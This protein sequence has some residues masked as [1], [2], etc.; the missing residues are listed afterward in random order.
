MTL[1]LEE[2]TAADEQDAQLLFREA[3]RRRR[4]LRIVRIGLVTAVVV[5]LVGFGLSFHRSSSSVTGPAGVTSQPGWP[6]HLRTGATLVYALNDLRVLNADSGGSR[7]LPLP[8]P[9]G[10]SRDLAMVSTGH[11]LVLNRGDTAW[12]YRGSLQS[13]PSD[14]GP[15]DGVFR[16]PNSDEAWVW[17]QPC[18]PIIG[19][20]NSNAPQM[21]SVHLI[22]SSG[23]QR[24]ATVA[25]PGDVGWYPTGL[26]GSA[27][28][29]L[30]QL[31]S[32]GDHD[33]QQEI[34]NPLTDRVVRVFTNVDLLGAGGSTVVWEPAAP[35]CTTRCSVHVLNVQ[36]GSQRTVHLPP[37]VT[38]TGDAAI[39]PDGSAIAITGAL[40]GSFHVPYPQAILLIG[41][42]SRVATVL[43]GSEQLTNPNLGPMGLTWSTN[44]WLFSFTVGVTTIHAWRPGQSQA[45]VLPN[46]RLPEVT[47]L[48]NEDPSLIA[49]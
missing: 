10:G 36:T 24:G 6:R 2:P 28:M 45:R 35:S 29:V 40:G 3:R 15:S 47:Y 33:D 25:L 32:Y 31:P 42:H 1:L 34:W 44:G 48:V 8:A 9:Y 19:C 14:L 26:A 49:L 21:G 17:S 4:R 20:T 5:A 43:A 23:R 7:V 12:L 22:D 30:S 39:A 46:L 18:D 37:D 16:G 11:S 38:V 41:T 13:Q 27:G